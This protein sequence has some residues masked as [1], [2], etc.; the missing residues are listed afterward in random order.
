VRRREPNVVGVAGIACSQRTIVK[1]VKEMATGVDTYPGTLK[2]ASRRLS[3][4]ET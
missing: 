4:T 3:N 2:D 1:S